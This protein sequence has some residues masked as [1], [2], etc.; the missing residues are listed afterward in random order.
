MCQFLG[1]ETDIMGERYFMVEESFAACSYIEEDNKQSKG[2][3][4]SCN[5]PFSEIHA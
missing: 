2:L 5:A 4:S 3:S 1:P